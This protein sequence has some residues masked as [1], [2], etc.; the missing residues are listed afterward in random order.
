MLVGKWRDQ[1]DSMKYFLGHLL[2]GKFYVSLYM[3][4]QQTKGINDAQYIG[5]RLR[6][7]YIK[8]K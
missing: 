6:I 1:R 8:N 5:F 2:M 7:A 4:Q 3:V